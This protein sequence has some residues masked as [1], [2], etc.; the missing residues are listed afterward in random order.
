VDGMTGPADEYLGQLRASLR[1]RPAETSRILA[2][3]EDHLRESVAAGLRAGMT[4][5][6]AQEAAVSA[7]GSVRAVV[8]AHQTRRAR[9]MA[10]LGG[11]AMTSWKLAGLSLLAFGVSGLVLLAETRIIHP[12][13]RLAP[14]AAPLAEPTLRGIAAGMVGLLLL[15]GC[16][17]ARRRRGTGAAPARA[18][19]YFPLAAAIFFGA[20]TIAQILLIISGTHVGGLPVLATLALAIGYGVRTLR[21]RRRAS[22]KNGTSVPA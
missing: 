3:A 8:R 5:V 17:L 9:A 18:A 20:G 16:R 21:P 19:R 12:G 14:G 6:E 11:C 2:E 15:A 22:Q 13:L 7:F 4:E 1:T 10:V